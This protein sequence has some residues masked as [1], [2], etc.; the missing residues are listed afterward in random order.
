MADWN[1]AE[2]IGAKPTPL[3]SSLYGEL[4]TDKVWAE[5]KK[6]LWIQKCSTSFSDV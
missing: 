6:E 4:I 2:M 1:P 5:L 3:S